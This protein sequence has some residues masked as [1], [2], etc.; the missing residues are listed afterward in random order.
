MSVMR[1]VTFIIS[2]FIVGMVEM[3]VAGIMNL[4]S[5]DLHVSEAWIGQL[6]TLYAVTFTVCGPILVKVTNRFSAKTVLLWTIAVFVFGNALIA[7]SPNF[8]LLI[9]GRII[10]SAAAA[11]IIVKILALTA[12]L[13]AP[14]NRGKMIGIVYSGFSGANVFGV[15]IGTMLG[16]WLGWRATFVFIIVVSVVAAF[17]MMRYLPTPAELSTASGDT[18]DTS[19]QYKILNRAEIIKYLAVTFMLLTAN[20]ITF[21]YINPLMLTNGYDIQFVSIILLVNGIA[22]TL[23]TS[24]GGFLADKLTSKTWLLIAA[25]AFTLSLAAVNWF[26]TNSIIIVLIIFIWNIMEWSTNPAVQSGLIDHVK[27][28]ASQVLSWNM[29]SLNAGIAAGGMIGG[30]I[31]S[32]IGVHAVAY[33]SSILG[34]VIVL[35]VLSIKQTQK[36][37]I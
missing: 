20:S 6:V 2:V 10:S 30:L 35:I 37:Q 23:G 19:S 16:G 7:V 36:P 9:I 21:V 1:I 14:Q 24:M 27:G 17:L 12:M 28:D 29:S 5:A 31:V 8:T 34:I 33:S 4:M 18:S 26:I 3:M 22:G 15:P 11:L 25:I 32:N 13:T